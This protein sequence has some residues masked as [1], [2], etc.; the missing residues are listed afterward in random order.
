MS[1]PT[2]GERYPNSSSPPFTF[3]HFQADHYVQWHL[4]TTSAHHPSEALARRCHVW[5]LGAHKST[6]LAGG[7]R[8]TNHVD[9]AAAT[10]SGRGTSPPSVPA[11][12]Q[13][14]SSELAHGGLQERGLAEH[15]R[16]VLASASH[17][18][19]GSSVA[20]R[21]R[22]SRIRDGAPAPRC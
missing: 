19:R 20:A 2:R 13:P 6:R 17:C 15:F 18:P 1:T 14:T 11:Y 10:V 21:L 3:L 16:G 5:N 9:V 22:G 4:H 12:R 7:L 8:S